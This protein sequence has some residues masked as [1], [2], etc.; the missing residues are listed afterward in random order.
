MPSKKKKKKSETK[1]N[2]PSPIKKKPKKT[3]AAPKSK[4]ALR[5]VVVLAEMP[6]PTVVISYEMIAERAFLIWERKTH[7]N[8]PE[9]NWI[10]A[11]AELRAE[12]LVGG[13]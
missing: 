3:V 2:K 4:P 10:E 1:K 12:L 8:Y 11:E 7:T 6:I 9:Q 13:K 5:P